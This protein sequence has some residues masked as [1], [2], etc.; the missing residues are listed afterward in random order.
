M[1]LIH[2]NIAFDTSDLSF[3]DIQAQFKAQYSTLPAIKDGET[4]LSD[5]F[6]IADYL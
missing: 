3:V 2:K 6:N 1:C 5:S 4:V